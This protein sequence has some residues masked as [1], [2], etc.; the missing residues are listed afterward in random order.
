MSGM[1]HDHS[2]T[3]FVLYMI[4]WYIRF[5]VFSHNYLVKICIRFL[6][7]MDHAS[8]GNQIHIYFNSFPVE[9][10]QYKEEKPD[11]FFN[12]L[13]VTLNCY[14]EAFKSL[15]LLALFRNSYKEIKV[16]LTLLYSKY[17]S[18]IC[19]GTLK[20]LITS[21]GS[22]HLWNFQNLSLGCL[23][24]APSL[25]TFSARHIGMHEGA[26]FITKLFHKYCWLLQ[27][28]IS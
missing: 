16:W 9:L 24:F 18:L 26:G 23:S 10:H 1:F 25:I 12:A 7:S 27:I 2:A 20:L 13:T 28:K 14:F 17:L 11:I 21:F 4:L 22:L 6:S 8:Q 15:R 5:S 3:I 19:T